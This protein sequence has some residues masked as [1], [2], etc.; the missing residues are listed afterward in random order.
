[1][2]DP[3]TVAALP[4]EEEIGE[5]PEAIYVYFNDNDRRLAELEKRTT[6]ECKIGM[7]KSGDAVGRILDQGV[8]TSMSRLPTVG[9]VIRTHDCRHLEKAI[10][11]ALRF[12]GHH[13]P[14]SPGSEWFLTSPAA[15]KRWYDHF[16]SA[17][18]SLR[19]AIEG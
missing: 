7:A 13:L 3:A 2:A 12:V 11:A 18:N 6:W 5:G 16:C 14:D 1:V 10:H 9:L 8:K 19:G 4:I 15:I 17:A